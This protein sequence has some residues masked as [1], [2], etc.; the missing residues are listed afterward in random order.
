MEDLN[1]QFN[2]LNKILQQWICTSREDY[3]TS[4]REYYYGH[5]VTGPIRQLNVG[6]IVLIDCSTPRS[7]CPIGKVSE[8]LPDKYGTLR[9][10]KV[11]SKGVLSTRTVDELLPL[12]IND[13]NSGEDGSNAESNQHTAALQASARWWNVVE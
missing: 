10:V 5:K 12:E 2:R 1:K 9:V 4:L 11:L 6:D 3:L 8:I 13:T 7:T